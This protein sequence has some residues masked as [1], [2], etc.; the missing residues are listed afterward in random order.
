MITRLEPPSRSG[1]G[2]H[3]STSA[4]ARAPAL[5]RASSSVLM[6]GVVTSVSEFVAP[7]QRGLCVGAT[8]SASDETWSASDEPWSASAHV[9]S[10]LRV[11]VAPTQRNSGASTSYSDAWPCEP[12]TVR[13][14][15]RLLMR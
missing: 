6:L 2:T 10:A 5:A 15:H 3:S 13:S 4:R 9:A 14:M 8:W 1:P 12:Y 7:V 11:Y